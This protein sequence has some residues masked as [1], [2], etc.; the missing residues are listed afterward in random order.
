MNHSLHGP[1]GHWLWACLSPP[2]TTLPI[3]APHRFLITNAYSVPV[4]VSWRVIGTDEA[5]SAA[6]SAAPDEDPSVSEAQV[7]TR[8][9]GPVE[10]S[11]EGRK[12]KTRANGAVPCTPP[13]SATAFAGV[14]AAQTGSWSA[15]FA[16]PIVAVHLHLMRTG[17]VLSWGDGGT[18]QVWDPATKTFTAYPSPIP[19]FCTGHAFTTDGR[20]VVFPVQRERGMVELYAHAA[21]ALVSH[22]HHDVTR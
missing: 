22:R 19:L 6:L 3:K 16:W 9:E 8:S 1:G 7:E 5:G 20:L 11:F 2:A 4:T 14:S 12:V 21:G 10:L 17:K 18:P 15:P 13:A